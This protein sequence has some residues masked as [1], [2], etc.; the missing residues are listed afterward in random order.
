MG[1]VSQEPILFDATI[2]DNI[3]FGANF[4]AV[5]NEEVEMAAKTADVH[6]FIMGLPQVCHC[7]PHSVTFNVTVTPIGI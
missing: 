2:A 6:N 7:H 3:R 1:L 4:R 5:S